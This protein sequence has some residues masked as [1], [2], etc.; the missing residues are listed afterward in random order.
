MNYYS[1]EAQNFWS[2]SIQNNSII[3]F[4]MVGLGS[5]FFLYF[6]LKSNRHDVINTNT[7]I[8]RVDNTEGMLLGWKWKCAKNFSCL[9]EYWVLSKLIT[10]SVNFCKP[11][12]AVGLPYTFNSTL[13]NCVL[14]TLLVR[15]AL[16]PLVYFV[17]DPSRMNCFPYRRFCLPFVFMESGWWE[18]VEKI[19]LFFE[20]LRSRICKKN[21]TKCRWQIN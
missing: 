20:T 12:L 13:Y 14:L 9:F 7:S 16:A 1:W 19:K 5:M 6:N 15:N 18:S 3:L 2:L 17:V 11:D 21:T 8:W 10:A 4:S